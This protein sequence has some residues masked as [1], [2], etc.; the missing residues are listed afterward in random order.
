M[1]HPDD[2]LKEAADIEAEAKHLREE[3]DR[4]TDAAYQ[5]LRHGSGATEQEV[6]QAR[7]DKER[8]LRMKV[9]GYELDDA[10][11]EMKSRAKRLKER[12]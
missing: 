10:A 9:R 4:I 1:P 11:Y 5:V 6:R 3:G 8:A 2:M 12:A 7:K